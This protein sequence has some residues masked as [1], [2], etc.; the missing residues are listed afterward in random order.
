MGLR[1]WSYD[2]GIAQSHAILTT[3]DFSPL[4]AKND[5]NPSLNSSSL[6]YVLYDLCVFESSIETK[7]T[8]LPPPP[9]WLLRRVTP[10]ASI[11]FVKS[12]L[13]TLWCCCLRCRAATFLCQLL[14]RVTSSVTLSPSSSITSL[15]CSL[16]CY[17]PWPSSVTLWPFL[18]TLL[19]CWY[20]V[21]V[22]SVV[23]LNQLYFCTAPSL[24][25]V[26]SLLSLYYVLLFDLVL[27]M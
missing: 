25:F 10:S 2:R 21:R 26:P 7:N 15:L 5:V 22:V 16:H 3:S 6:Y 1:S 18:A 13:E 23:C 11:D 19:H 27:C 9:P 14:R 17:A 12:K 20:L 24:L 4:K 8:L